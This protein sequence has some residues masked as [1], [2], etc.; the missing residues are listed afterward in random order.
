MTA[1][2]I[3][4]NLQAFFWPH[5]ISKLY[6]FTTG[7]AFTVGKDKEVIHN[8]ELLSHHQQPQLSIFTLWVSPQRNY[9]GLPYFFFSNLPYFVYDLFLSIAWFFSMHSTLGVITSHPVSSPGLHLSSLHLFSMWF[10][11]FPLISC[12]HL[13]SLLSTCL[14]VS[15]F[16]TDS[17][18]ST[19]TNTVGSHILI[20]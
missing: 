9:E 15:L 8:T 7:F 1:K 5:Y 20:I 2:L 13:K 10:S 11:F 17:H 4:E 12:A 18:T 14:C 19:H 16:V 3:I 6:I